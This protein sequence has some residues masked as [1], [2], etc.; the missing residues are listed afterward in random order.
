MREQHPP[1][2]GQKFPPILTHGADHDIGRLTLPLVNIF[3]AE[4]QMKL[5]I[6][7]GDMLNKVVSDGYVIGK[8]EHLCKEMNQ[9][10]ALIAM[11]LKEKTTKE[12][13]KHT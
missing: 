7:V 12:G 8:I 3:I 10:N 11:I 1:P 5:R 13:K 6:A 2:L 9:Q 4:F